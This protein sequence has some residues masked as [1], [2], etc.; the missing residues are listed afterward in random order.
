MALVLPFT[1]TM[2]PPQTIAL[3]AC[4]YIGAEYGG[5]IPAILIRTPSRRRS[6][7]N[8]GESVR[9]RRPGR[10]LDPLP[11]GEDPCAAAGRGIP[12]KGTAHARGPSHLSRPVADLALEHASGTMFRASTSPSIQVLRTDRSSSSCQRISAGRCEVEWGLFRRQARRGQHGPLIRRGRANHKGGFNAYFHN[13]GSTRRDPRC[14][15][16]HGCT[17]RAGVDHAAARRGG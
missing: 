13:F 9:S 2:D 3:L 4:V 12:G 8:G 7:L 1:Y 10:D 15:M 6:D 5:S 14:P 17:T 11:R 16:G